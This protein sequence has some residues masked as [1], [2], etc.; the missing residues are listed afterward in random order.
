M[1]AAQQFEEWLMSFETIDPPQARERLT[2]ASGDDW[3][4]VDV[5]SPEE[6]EAGHPPGAFNVPIALVGPDGS[7]V[8]AN[9]DFVPAMR[10]CFEPGRKLILGC[11]AGGRSIRACQTLAAEGYSALANM[12]G[13]YH[14][15]RGPDGS[16]QQEGW[17]GHGFESDQGQPED[18]SWASIRAR[19]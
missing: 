16:L 6:F 2:P 15:M 19:L 17:S 5:R 13:G 8:Q 3:T 11:A 7:G 12:H 10:A 1:L 18:R 4:Y 9:P 14:G